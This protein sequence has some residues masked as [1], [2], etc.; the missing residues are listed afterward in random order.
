MDASR[1][2]NFSIV[3]HIDHGKSTIA[4]RLLEATG[5]LS[6]RDQ[7]DQFLDNMELE[8]ERGITT[9]AK[10]TAVVYKDTTINLVDTPGHA[11]FTAIRAR[12]ARVTD[13]AVLVVAAD[14]GLMPLSLIHI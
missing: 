8:R 5:A 1:I 7:Q 12:G 2:R 11:A 14:D 9:T 3:A 13:I 4:D 6:E 10:N